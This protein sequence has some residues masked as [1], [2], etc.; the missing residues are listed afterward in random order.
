MKIKYGGNPNELKV[1]IFILIPV[2]ICILFIL[3]KLGYSLSGSTIDV[4]LKVDNISNIKKGTSIKLKGYEIGRI[5]ELRPVYK[6][7]LHFLATMRIIKDI[8]LNENCSAII[9]NQNII[10]DT[11]IEIKNSDK[12][13]MLLKDGDVIE[14]L[15]YVNLEAVL[16]DVHNLLVAT[17]ETINILKDVSQGS[18]HNIKSVIA[19]LDN[20]VKNSQGDISKIVKNVS[21]ATGQANEIAAEFKKSPTK[22]ILS[23]SKSQSDQSNTV[24]K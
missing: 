23:G 15:E 6:P 13:G 20:L 16:T 4:Y 21:D 2:V 18:K 12:M 1:G 11:V 7:E 17:T 8:D 24:K 10:G 9:L 3:L 14:G 5:V 22:F 19:N